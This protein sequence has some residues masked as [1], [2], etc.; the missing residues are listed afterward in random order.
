MKCSSIFYPRYLV[1]EALLPGAEGPEILRGI[2][3][4]IA[5]QFH[6]D[7]AK[8]LTASRQV[9]EHPVSRYIEVNHVLRPR[10]R[11]RSDPLI[12]SPP[13]PVLFSLDPDPDPTCNNGYIKSFLF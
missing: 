7:P 1:S 11:I 13:D 5:A 9:E 10:M 3:H 12:F 6:G 4:H 2:R 8:L